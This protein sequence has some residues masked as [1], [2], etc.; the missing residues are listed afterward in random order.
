[1]IEFSDDNLIGNKKAVKA[2]LPHLVAWQKA[3]GYPFEF[4]SEASLNLA[5]DD[6]I[7]G[8]L[9]EANFFAVFIGIE[10][11]DPDVLSAMQ[12]K[13][14]TR[15]D[16]VDNIHKIQGYGI[17]V[18]AGFIVGFDNEGDSVGRGMID[19][20]EMACI[21]ICMVGLLYALPNTQLTRR[22]QKEGRLHGRHDAALPDETDQCTAG[23]NFDT[24]RPRR[25]VLGDYRQV[26]E[27]IYDVDVYFDRVTRAV[28]HL[29]CSGPNG[30]LHAPSLGRNLRDFARFLW[31]VT[32]TRPDMRG[33]VWRLMA[34][35]AWRNPRS[36]RAAMYMAAI[37]AHLGPYS[38]SVM[39]Q[40]E[41]QMAE[42]P[43]PPAAP[44]SP[45]APAPRVVAHDAA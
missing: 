20:I 16:I 9:R 27:R 1:V 34:H 10:S 11:P 26:L 25:D 43:A 42:A 23:L 2:F 22:L 35:V 31:S 12:K 40:L 21:P 33:R 45:P 37:F 4:A 5:D 29:D 41:R 7:L 44:L 39:R 38:R 6:Q 8:L 15:R 32:R 13:Q 19:L 24:L 28:D 18:L 14:N 36:I 3:H 17:F 30:V